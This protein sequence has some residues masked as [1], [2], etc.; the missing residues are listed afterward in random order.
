M[1]TIGEYANAHNP[2]TRIMDCELDA[3]NR[4]GSDRKD[5][6]KQDEAYERLPIYQGI[7]MNP[8]RW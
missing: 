3:A 2:L 4:N 1:K 6:Q 7:V 5:Y 8:Q